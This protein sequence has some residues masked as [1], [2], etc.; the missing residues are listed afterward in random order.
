MSLSIT[1]VLGA[2]PIIPVLVIEELSQAVPLAKALYLGGLQVLE[3]TLRTPVA[4]AA[5]REIA[6]E[7]PEAVV[8]VGTVINATDIQDAV[9]AGAS[10]MVS[11]GSTKV[12][13]DAAIYQDVPLLPGAASAS[14]AMALLERGFTHM[15]FFPAEA[16]GGVALL[17]S[18]SGPLPQITFCPT[19]GI[20]LEKAPDYLE[21][22][23]V[24]CVGGSWMVPAALLRDQSWDEIERMARQAALLENK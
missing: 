12:L 16:A 8:G 15:K 1:D 21:L 20:T 6:Q 14:E 24:A 3:I 23:N 10:F 5:V 7:L 9:Q 4:L 11:P 17:K 13:L 22:P 19:G 18:L 2:S